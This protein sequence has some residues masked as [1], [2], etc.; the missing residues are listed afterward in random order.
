MP[1][2][3]T[4]FPTPPQPDKC[5]EGAPTAILTNASWLVLSYSY[6]TNALSHAVYVYP[7]VASLRNSRATRALS[8]EMA[9]SITVVYGNDSVKAR[10]P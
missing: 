2:Q 1:S 10:K 6:F 3:Y 8:R 9:M 7:L 4:A 5:W